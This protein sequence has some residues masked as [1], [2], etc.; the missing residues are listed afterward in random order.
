MKRMVRTTLVAAAA[1]AVMS[2]AAFA[3]KAQMAGKGHD[4][5]A[6][7]NTGDLC[8]ACHTSHSANTTYP[9]LLW[10]RNTTT[11]TGFTYYNS[12][13]VNGDFKGG[14]VDITAG[15]KI[16]FLCMSCHDGTIALDSVLRTPSGTTFKTGVMPTSSTALL[17]KDL[18][19]DHPVAFSYD[20][21]QA[22]LPALYKATP[23]LAKL[24]ATTTGIRRVECSSCHDVHGI[25]AKMLRA[26]NTNSQLCLDCHL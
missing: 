11:T 6:T 10:N 20:S 19:N 4:I 8:G 5:R 18:S 13:T 9:A 17:S 22:A 12:T 21:S 16:S 24:F 1:L 2:G 25:A 7:G 26:P 14:A 3:Q 15:N 23:T